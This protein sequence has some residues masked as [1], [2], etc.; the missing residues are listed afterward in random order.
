MRTKFLIPLLIVV[1]NFFCREK[2]F[3]EVKVS[4]SNFIPNTVFV[5]SEDLSSPKFR[6]LKDKY[7]LDT[8][9]HGEQDELK[10]ILLLRNWIKGKNKHWRF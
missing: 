7:Q 1:I 10:R 4:N 9:F 5:S 2:S 3:Y 6:E 8:V